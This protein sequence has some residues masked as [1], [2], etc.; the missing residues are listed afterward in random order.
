[1]QYHIRRA[2]VDAIS[3][4]LKKSAQVR[5][6]T[7]DQELW[8]LRGPDI[9]ASPFDSLNVPVNTDGPYLRYSQGG[10]IHY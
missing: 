1:M 5:K 2:T 6:Q 3:S 9:G 10:T 7:V 4:Y 8:A